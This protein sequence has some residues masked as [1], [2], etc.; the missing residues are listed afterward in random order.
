MPPHGGHHHHHGGGGFRGGWYGPSWGNELVVVVDDP[1]ACPVGTEPSIAID[2]RRYCRPVPD[3]T[4]AFGAL[5]DF[6]S[7]LWQGLTFS[8]IDLFTSANCKAKSEDKL[9]A[10]DGRIEQ[11][12]WMYVPPAMF[13]WDQVNTVV[14]QLLAI[15][16]VTTDA[17]EKAN[18]DWTQQSLYDA[19]ARIF[20]TIGGK[21]NELLAA[22]QP[23]SGI[24]MKNWIT[25][26]LIAVS[27]GMKAMIESYCAR[28]W[29][30][31]ALQSFLGAVDKIW[32]FLAAIGR[33][34]KAVYD[35][36]VYV[37]WGA[38]A[39]IAYVLYNEYGG[40]LGLKKSRGSKRARR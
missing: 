4:D 36:W 21:A 31:S 2:G 1:Y 22:R 10:F 34:I 8:P 23:V 19:Q 35:H 13:T 32:N 15:S 20:S 27:E 18:R 3:A 39:F 7:S 28:P 9:K 5:G 33:G 24:D 16:K 14:G 37:K 38:A 12:K 11:I 29:W 26:S 25:S 6:W 17:I 40:K 30:F